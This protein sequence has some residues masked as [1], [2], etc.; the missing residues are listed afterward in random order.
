M[1]GKEVLARIFEPTSSREFPGGGV[2]VERRKT[3]N[4]WSRMENE[5]ILLK[6]A[7]VTTWNINHWIYSGSEFRHMLESVGF[8]EVAIYGDLEG[9]PYDHRAKRLVVVA[10]R[11]G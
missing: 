7:R 2:F 1:M 11:P 5:W 9:S 4:H 8:G 3:V 6:D 10:A